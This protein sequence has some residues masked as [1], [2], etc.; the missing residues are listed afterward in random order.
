MHKR[1]NKAAK[2]VTIYEKAEHF[3]QELRAGVIYNLID[4]EETAQSFLRAPHDR[5]GGPRS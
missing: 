5:I 3:L 1:I 4:L 2:S